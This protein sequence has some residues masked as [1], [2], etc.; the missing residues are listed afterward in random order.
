MDSYEEKELI[1]V[2]IPLYNGEKHIIDCLDSVAKQTYDMLEILVVDDGSKD[3]GAALVKKYQE[4]EPRVKLFQ[5]ENGGVSS[6]RNLGLQRAEGKYIMFL[7]CDDTIKKDCCEVLVSLI[8]KQSC[9]MAG[10]SYV[11]QTVVKGAVVKESELR[12]PDK[13]ITSMEEFVKTFSV[14]FD[15][16]IY[17]SV[18]GK[19]Y[20][21]AVLD[22]ARICFQDG[23]TIGEDMLFNF[24][25]FENSIN[26]SI[27]DYIGYEYK[28]YEDEHSAS[29]NFDKGKYE[30]AAYLYQRGIEFANQLGIEDNLKKTLLKYYLRSCFFQMEK[31]TDINREYMK[32]I[33][34]DITYGIGQI[35]ANGDKEFMLYKLVCRTKS[36][37]MIKFTVFM[38]KF[39]R[40]LARG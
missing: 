40:K 36:V 18:C 13:N 21:K 29:S 28:V 34:N 33:D 8:R 3:N 32:Y 38:R 27:V 37:N 39:A 35:E 5:K 25:F 9:D 26:V 11:F 22:L 2:I 14:F 20:K 12:V 7:D 1:S 6:A 17:L 19:L 24:K 15:N 16:K 31:E 10:G 30:N 4:K 23:I